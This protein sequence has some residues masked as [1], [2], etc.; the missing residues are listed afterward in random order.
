[1]IGTVFDKKC[2]W[3][4]GEIASIGRADRKYCSTKCGNKARNKKF[5]LE[6]RDKYLANRKKTNDKR[7]ST[8]EGKYLDHKHRAKQCGIEFN[9]TFDEWWEIWQPHYEDR[10]IGKLVMCR[11]N[12]EGSYEVGNV[13]IDTQANNNREACETGGRAR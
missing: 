6:S 12:D 3:C 1:M 10:G 7:R 11:F 9:L 13:R 2:R 4:C 5:Q 8:P